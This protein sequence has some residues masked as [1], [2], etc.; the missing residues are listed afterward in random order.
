MLRAERADQL[1]GQGIGEAELEIMRAA[2]ENLARIR[3]IA[4]MMLKNEKTCKLGVKSKRAK[5]GYDRNYLLT[6]LGVNPNS[7]EKTP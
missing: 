6:L 7:D 2:A 5:A 1:A 4:V 3:R